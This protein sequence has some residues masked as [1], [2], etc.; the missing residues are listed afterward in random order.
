MSSA[1]EV[2]WLSQSILWSVAGSIAAVV[3]YE[4]WQSQR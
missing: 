3:L 2:A 1:Q 4:L